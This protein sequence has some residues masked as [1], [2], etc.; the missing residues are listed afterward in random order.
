MQP[1]SSPR[2]QPDA[3]ELSD[4]GVTIALDD[5][6]TGYSSLSYLHSF[7]FGKVKIDRSFLP[8]IEGERALAPAEGAVPRRYRRSR[9]GRHSGGSSRLHRRQHARSKS[10]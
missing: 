4:L 2:S 8:G 5:I 7:P 10:R 6:G 3:F 1:P 9:F